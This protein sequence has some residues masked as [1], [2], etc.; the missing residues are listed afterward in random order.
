M[1]ARFRSI[2]LPSLKRTIVFVLITSFVFTWNNFYPI[3][4]LTSGGP[5]LSTETF[6]VYAYQEAFSY[7][8]FSLAAAWSM[9]STAIVM[10]MAILMIRYTHI[11]DT[12]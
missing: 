5:G 11:L 4:I 8:N 1:L 9:L 3:Y 6:I 12:A 7:S 2:T 10:V